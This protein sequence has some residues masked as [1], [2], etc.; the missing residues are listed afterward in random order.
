MSNYTGDGLGNPIIQINIQVP[1]SGTTVLVAG[2]VSPIGGP[3]VTVT[4]SPLTAPVVPGAGTTYWIIQAD[5]TTG[6]LS[7]KTSPSAM[8]TADAGAIMIFGDT[9]PSTDSGNM[10][11]N[12]TDQTPDTY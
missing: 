9:I 10:A 2:I 6:A 1:D 7:T 12:A 8:P 5:L 4:G 11:L 3:Q